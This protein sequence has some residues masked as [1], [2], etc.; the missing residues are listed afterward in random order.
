MC[1]IFEKFIKRLRYFFSDLELN[2]IYIPEPHEKGD[3]HIHLLLKASKALYIHNSKLSEI[4]GQG[5]VKVNR[6]K[7]VDNIGAYVSAYLI[8]IKNGEETKKGARLYLY[9]VGHQLYRCSKGIAKP[10]CEY[11]PYWKAK[12]KVSSAKLT[13]SNSLKVTTD[14]GFS[15]TITT[16][17]YNS[18]RN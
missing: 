10:K 5:F 8:D 13:Y 2:Y 12:E 7:D 15:N 1:P 11:L 4:W 6:L 14:K 3:W 18:K 9:P 16:E 17:Y